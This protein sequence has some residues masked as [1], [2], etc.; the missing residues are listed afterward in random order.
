MACTSEGSF[1][2]PCHSEEG[3]QVAIHLG[4]G[5]CRVKVSAI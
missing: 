5:W 2:L 4:L 1:S 3:M